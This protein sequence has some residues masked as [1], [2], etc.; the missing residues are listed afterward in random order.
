MRFFKCRFNEPKCKSKWGCKC[1]KSSQPSPPPTTIVQPAP[2]AGQ[3]AE[4]VYQAQLKYDPLAA[5]QSYNILTND[6]YGLKPT[7]QF[8]EDT[9]SQIFD[10]ESAVRDQLAQ[11]VLANLISPTGISPEQQ[12]GINSRRQQSQSEL[13]KAMRERANLGGG[14]FG[15]RAANSEARAVGELQNQFAEEDIQ[16]EERAR[17]NSIQ[18]ALPF[19][20]ILFPE[21]GLTAPQF[22]SPV[23]NPNVAQ[24][25]ALTGRGQDYNYLN[26][27]NQ[28]NAQ[29][30]SSLYQALGQAAGAA[31]GAAMAFC[32][33]AAEVFGSWENPKT[34]FCRMYI[35]QMAPKWFRESYIKFGERV[36]K[37]IHDK[38]ILKSIIKP[39]F[40]LFAYR[41]WLRCLDG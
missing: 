24:Q 6:Q 1:G 32:W 23:V 3:T 38:P 22:Q 9:R 34:T 29:M 11:N 28:A 33:V 27:Q 13:Q 21:V 2:T 20:Q 35:A 14:L 10:Q 16:R 4:D 7:T 17:L 25:N 15:G 19:L 8:L 18:A 41:G 31:G 5:Q 30:R 37:F 12:S 26:I 36:A 40:E 39:L